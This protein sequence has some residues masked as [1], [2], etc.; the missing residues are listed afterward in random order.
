[1]SSRLPVGLGLLA[2][3]AT[4]I[5]VV[6][7]VVALGPDASGASPS[8]APTAV[9]PLTPVPTPGADAAPGA[10]PSTTASNPSTSTPLPGQAPASASPSPGGVAFRVG[11]PA[12]LLAVPQVGGG[13]VDLAALRGRPVWVEFMASWCPS[14]RDDFPVMNRYAI[15]Y[16]S[17]G[18]VVLAIDVREDEGTAARFANSLGATFP[19][20]LDEDGRAAQTWGAVA[21]PIHFFV[22]ASGTIRDGAA[23]GVPPELVAAAL[24]KIMPGVDVTP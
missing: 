21:L 2:G 10:T 18:L 23:G 24:G 19:I 7:A 9:A 11:D 3:V 16:A 17:N 22:D 5:V 12:P 4:T 14:C 6:V 20:G 1:M 8:P 13:R 15:R